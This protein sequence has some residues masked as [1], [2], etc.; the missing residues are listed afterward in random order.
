M[1]DYTPE[2][3]QKARD[4]LDTYHAV[5]DHVVDTI[6]FTVI[7]GMS[8]STAIATLRAAADI[9][10]YNDRVIKVREP[11]QIPV[12]ERPNPTAPQIL[13]PGNNKIH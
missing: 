7:M 11:V 12:T 1:K 10:E 6:A 3:I 4:I 2:D 5:Y 8:A 9:I 13:S